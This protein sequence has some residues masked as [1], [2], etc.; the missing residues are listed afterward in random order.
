M[1][2]YQRGWLFALTVLFSSVSVAADNVIVRYQQTSDIQLQSIVKRL[3]SDSSIQDTLSLMNSEFIF[4]QP[5]TIVFGGDDGPLYDPAT[6]YILIP[7]TFLDEVELR[8]KAVNYADDDNGKT[9]PAAINQAVMDVVI[10]TL[11]HELAHA[12]IA[13][14]ELPIVGKEEDAA[15][16]LAAVLSIEYFENGAEIAISAAELFYL[17]GDEVTEFEEA[18]F[19]DEHSLDLQ[20]YYA[21]LCH[22]YGSDDVNY[23]YLLKDTGFS[24]ERGDFC[25]SEYDTIANNWLT[26]LAPYMTPVTSEDTGVNIDSSPA[27]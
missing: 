2:G 8:F 26:L 4:E 12:L 15:D 20:R 16:N 1:Q 14:H 24:T 3:Q 19:W 7:Y 9:D 25:I 10:H 23:A 18:D 21:T 22:V 27:E 5:L 11:F 6:N 17:E 13:N